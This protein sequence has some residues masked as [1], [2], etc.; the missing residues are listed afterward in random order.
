MCYPIIIPTLNRFS[1]FKACIESLAACFHASETELIIGLDFPPA[2][3]Y[4]D[5][6]KKIK[7]YIPSIKGFKNVECFERTENYGSFK[8]SSELQNYVL[9][10]YDAYIYTEDDN[11]FSPAF[12]DFINKGLERYRDDPDVVSI[13]GYSYPIKWETTASAILQH[14]YFSAWGYGEWGKKRT[15]LL[16]DLSSEFIRKAL[17]D[18]ESLRQLNFSPKN[19]IM[20]LFLFNT[21]EISCI[22]I[23]RSLYLTITKKYVLM[24]TVSLVKNNG[25][26][27]SGEHC[28]DIRLSIFKDQKICDPQKLNKNSAQIVVFSENLEKFQ[29]K[30]F[31]NR[32]R[33]KVKAFVI[34]LMI[35]I[36]GFDLAKKLYKSFKELKHGIK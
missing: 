30:I 14:Q 2:E 7:E 33:N 8:N 19:K 32:N 20:T 25:W 3:K 9:T 23:V 34:L 28:C 21:E 13:C 6:W 1:H 31:E 5:G 24:P 26:D 12:L 15:L 29:M 10:K 18:K 27:G 11:I 4:I 22:D 35:K 16:N 17:T 36:L